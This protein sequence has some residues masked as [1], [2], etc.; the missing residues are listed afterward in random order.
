MIY[1]NIETANPNDCAFRCFL[2]G[3]HHITRRFS[4]SVLLLG[5]EGTPLFEE[6][7]SVSLSPEK[8]Y[9]Q[10]A[11]LFQTGNRASLS[12]IYF[13]MHFDGEFWESEISPPLTL[14]LKGTF[15]IPSVRPLLKSW[16]I[17]RKKRPVSGCLKFH[18]FE[19][20]CISRIAWIRRRKTR[21][22][23]KFSQRCPHI[24]SSQFPW[25]LC[26]RSGIL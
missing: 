2:D 26:Q 13:Y 11:D 12:P 23:T 21:F 20:C 10:R 25:G 22:L 8:W 15:E 7:K 9:I 1:L 5:V 24:W 14:P 19:A 17:V 16:C 18:S 6:E 4:Q 3:E